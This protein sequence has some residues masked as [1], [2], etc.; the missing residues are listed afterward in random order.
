[1]AE[2]QRSRRAERVKQQRMKMVLP[3]YKW[4]I[5]GVACIVGLTLAAALAP[6]NL[7]PAGPCAKRI[8]HQHAAFSMFVEDQQVSFRDPAYYYET[9][10]FRDSVHLHQ[11]SP[12][13]EVATG[14]ATDILHIEGSFPCGNPTWTL[15]Q[16]LGQY[17]VTIE[18]GHLKLDTRDHHNGT[19]WRDNGNHTLQVY[20]SKGNATT[21]VRG[22]FEKFAGD[23]SAYIPVSRDKI[24]ITFGAPTPEELLRQQGTLPDDSVPYEWKNQGP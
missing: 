6:P 7:L 19:D 23:L 2:D 8:T 17:G 9:T 14:D 10:N 16:V 24:L 12:T 11:D 4:P 20:V 21:G 13:A 18:Q 22:A 1:M 3:R 15:A 5:I